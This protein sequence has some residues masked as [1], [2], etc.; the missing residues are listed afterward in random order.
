MNKQLSGMLRKAAYCLYGLA[1]VI[2]LAGFV[3]GLV[4]QPASAA[5]GLQSQAAQQGGYS[6]TWEPAGD[7]SICMLQAGTISTRVTVHTPAGATVNLQ[8]QYYIQN[9]PDLRTS[10]TYQIIPNVSDGDTFTITSPWP[11]VR[12]ADTIVEI[13]FGANLL[14]PNTNN[15][16]T[17]TATGQ[18][19]FWTPSVCPAPTAVPPSTPVTPTATLLATDTATPS[20]TPVTPTPTFT[21]TPT[22]TFSPSATPTLPPGVTPS[23]TSTP[24]P[25]TPTIPATLTPTEPVTPTAT[26]TAPAGVTPAATNTPVGVSPTLPAGVTPSLPAA[27]STPIATLPVPAATGTQSALIAVTGADLTQPVMPFG[28]QQSFLYNLGLTALGLALVCHGISL[29]LKRK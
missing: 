25:I 3:L 29:R 15:P 4:Y 6:V 26:S 11:G 5:A 27:S 8:T 9:P 18:D 10:P 13:H 1:A 23:I 21:Q 7:Q 14:D 12:P 17:G 19:W 2:L 24:T 28:I 16:I 22:Q 20:F